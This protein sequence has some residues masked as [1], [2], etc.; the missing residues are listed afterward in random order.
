MDEQSNRAPYLSVPPEA[1]RMD[2]FLPQGVNSQ[3]RRRCVLVLAASFGVIAA[4]LPL[5]AFEYFKSGPSVTF[6][7]FIAGCAALLTVPLI[8]RQTKSPTASGVIL[9]SVMFIALSVQSYHNGGLKSA[10]IGWMIAVPLLASSV[11]GGRFGATILGCVLLLYAAFFC[12]DWIGIQYPSE[13]PDAEHRIWLFVGYASLAIF[14]GWFGWTYDST[15]RRAKERLSLL[16]DDLNKSNIELEKERDRA[17][18]A[19]NAKTEFLANMSH[20]L[21]TPLNAVIGMTDL[22]VDTK[23]DR[24][25]FEY[26]QTVRSSG[27]ALLTLVN[28]LL[29]FAKNDASQLELEMRPIALRHLI[30]EAMDLVAGV[31]AR[32][33]IEL[34]CLIATSV[35][36]HVVLD[37]NRF[38]QVLLN[39][40]SNAVKFTGEGEVFLEVDFKM[41]SL[42]VS[43]GDSGIGMSEEVIKTLFN[44]F[45]QADPSVSRKYGGTGLGLAITKQ[46]VD[47]FGGSIKVES[48]PGSGSVFSFVV[49]AKAVESE[50]HRTS[51]SG[52]TLLGKRVL[53]V[54]DHERNRRQMEIYSQTLGMHA[55]V[56]DSGVVAIKV[57]KEESFDL[58]TVDL[59]MPIMDGVELIRHIKSTYKRLPVISIAPV[60]EV[61]DLPEG[62][63]AARLSKPVRISAFADAAQYAVL[64]PTRAKKITRDSD[65]PL[66]DTY[67]LSILLAE[68]NVVNQKVA[69]AMLKRLGYTI[70]IVNNGAE[71]IDAVQVGN[72]DL[73]LMDVQMPEVDGLEATRQIRDLG[74]SVSIVAMTANAQE[75]DRKRCFQAGMNGFIPK[76]VERLSLDRILRRVA[77]GRLNDKRH[78]DDSASFRLKY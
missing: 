49:P 27:N 75:E 33:G 64:T 36:S 31:A 74:H 45:T 17:E 32:K 41:E 47:A 9:C 4:A 63:V 35:P 15:Q 73:V 37:G 21:R 20:E 30:E 52:D 42:S 5:A 29:D 24:T 34:T 44:P 61:D 65:A 51:H 48:E 66:A 11:V 69:E 78:L 23:L 22:L 6:I 16:I 58:V 67:P 8:L 40:L 68:D 10:S 59:V 28:T 7:A 55:T 60:G 39:L 38:R 3:T 71:A 12:M 53:I 62:E 19:A 43:I 26:A 54:D 76:P 2:R 57:L 1:S 13:P 50:T 77:T 56:V 72:F 46:I 25:Q 14:V 18:S 70:T